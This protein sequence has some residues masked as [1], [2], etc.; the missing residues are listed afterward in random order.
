MTH[1]SD[2]TVVQLRVFNTNHKSVESKPLYTESQTYM[3]HILT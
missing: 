1:R 3:G 2:K